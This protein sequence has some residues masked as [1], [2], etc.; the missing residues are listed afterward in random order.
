VAEAAVDVERAAQKLLGV[1]K[2][3]PHESDV[4]E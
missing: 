1:A 2:A 3:V 4:A